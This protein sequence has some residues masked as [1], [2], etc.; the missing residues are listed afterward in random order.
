MQALTDLLAAL[1]WRRLRLSLINQR[2]EFARE[3]PLAIFQSLLKHGLTA[4]MAVASGRA[5]FV[6]HPVAASFGHRIVKGGKYDIELI[7]PHLGLGDVSRFA[8]NLA[9]HLADPAN[10]FALAEASA[11]ETRNLATL[12]RECPPMPPPDAA[13]WLDVAGRLDFDPARGSYDWRI[14]AGTLFGLMAARLNSLYG[15]DISPLAGLWQNV[16][17]SSYFW[18]HM[19]S[20]HAAKSG[21]APDGAKMLIQGR[22]GP[23]CLQRTPPD[24][25]PLLLICSELHIGAETTYGRGYYRLATDFAYLEQRICDPAELRATLAEIAEKSDLDNEIDREYFSRADA[26]GELAARLASGHW[27]PETAHLFTI[28][29]KSGGERPICTISAT[30]R[31]LHRHLHRLLQM[32]FDRMFEDCAIGFRPKRSLHTARELIDRAMAEGCRFVAESDIASFFDEID[33][34]ILGDKLDAALPPGET[35][36]RD[37]LRRIIATPV[38]SGGKTI[39]RARGLLQGSPLSPL[40]ANFYLDAFD[41]KMLAK[42]YRLVRYADDFVILTE[43]RE[44]AE[45]ALTDAAAFLA[46]E[47]LSLKP[48]KTGIQAIDLGFTFLGLPFGGTGGLGAMDAKTLEQ[49]ILRKPLYIRPLYGFIGMDYDA[50]VV[51]RGQELLQRLPLARIREIVIFGQHL[52]STRVLQR[53]SQEGIPVSFC[54]PTGAFINTLA[55]DSRRFHDIEARHARR[56]Q[57]MSE[58]EKLAMAASIVA[59]KIHNYRGWASVRF[60]A[61]GASAIA[62]LEEELAALPQAA[63]IEELRGHEGIAARAVFALVAEM[64]AAKGFVSA[65]REPYKKRD[66]LNSLLDFAYFLLTARLNTL[67]RGRGLNPYL[68]WLHS[69]KDY[70]ESLVYD[71][72]EPFRFRMDAMVLR[73]INQEM[74][75]KDDLGK[76][77][78]KGARYFL[79]HEATGRFIA[80]FERELL[81]ENEED[82]CL[83]NLLDAQVY[84]ITRWLDDGELPR[85]YRRQ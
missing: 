58:A 66:E 71:L 69:D 76:Q 52:V 7:F 2:N 21:A 26:S 65:G 79:G 84:Q 12:L 63:N 62:I 1:E 33:W 85:L 18:E 74:V 13:I 47:K 45:A 61:A 75:K 48:E 50:V 81:G 37:L 3:H 54:S 78:D 22:E 30:D 80:A 40:L 24:L 60:E 5:A 67:L 15:L 56:H 6:F 39:L 72:A 29:K 68:G 53:C 43:T 57:A 77:A 82:N 55:P 8:A 27:R 20:A 17:L 4:D 64:A 10:N 70:Y 44:Q 31:L 51:K 35:L 25:L 23:I 46:E 11:P 73:M 19:R 38:E 42:G 34:D 83:G 49:T 14:E 16:R 59:A 36:C 9:R 28:P 41:E 32:P